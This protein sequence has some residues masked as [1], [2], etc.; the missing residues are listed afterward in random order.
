MILWS[1]GPA[2]LHLLT[3]HVLLHPVH[4]MCTNGGELLHVDMFTTRVALPTEVGTDGQRPLL[5]TKGNTNV[6]SR[7]LLPW[8]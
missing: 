7:T 1:I 5:I 8:L 6:V 3:Q 4:L 2:A